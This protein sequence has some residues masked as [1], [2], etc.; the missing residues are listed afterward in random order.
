INTTVGDLDGNVERVLRAPREAE[1]AGCDLA[2]FPELA[3]T[4]YPPEHPLLKPGVVVDTRRA[5]HRAAAA[6]G[7]CAVVVGVLDAGR[8]LYNAA[9][10]CARGRVHAVY[11]KRNLP[12]YAVFDEQRNF[13][14]GQAASPLV[15]VAGV[16]VGVSVC[17]D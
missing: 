11:H 6:T 9:A 16:R 1:E 12:N 4:G 8:D 15:E 10:V 13:A 5:L 3:P 17:E 2:A 7:E 14:P